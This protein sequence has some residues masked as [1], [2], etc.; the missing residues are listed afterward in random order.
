M[1]TGGKEGAPVMVFWPSLMMTNTMWSY[2][3]EYYA[4]KYRVVLIDSPGVGK[5]DAPRKLI[6][7]EDCRD[8]L[9]AI[10]DTL[11][12][13]RCFFAGNSCGAMLAAVLP[14][15]IPERL[16]G[17]GVINGAA[18]LPT[19]PET[20]IMTL[21]ANALAMYARTPRWWVE[22]VAKA[23]FSGDTAEASNPEF[24]R[25]LDCVYEDDPNCFPGNCTASCSA[26]R[27]GTSC[28]A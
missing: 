26:A 8:T 27:T 25:Y 16:H 7:L 14:A 1:W 13:E 23:A 18:S 10:L 2:Q 15:W 24:M 12:I 17:T 28:C 19:M 3:Y 20:I 21:R 11:K 22:T 5:S 4:P 6:L 9:V